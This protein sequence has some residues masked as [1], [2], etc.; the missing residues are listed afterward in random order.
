MKKVTEA[1]FELK[2]VKILEKGVYAKFNGTQPL[3]NDVNTTNKGEFT[4]KDAPHP[5]FAKAFDLLLPII[6]YDEGAGD[7]SDYTVK[8]LSFKN[9]STVKISHMKQIESGETIR[10]SGWIS[11]DNEEF[12]NRK[13][14]KAA[15][16]KIKHEAYEYFINNKRLQL[17]LAVEDAA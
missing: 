13:E 6:A 14:L 3:G 9:D 12:E 15:C 2:A 10:N 8:G 16:E 4:N 5:D 1:N 11:F 7:I 17:K